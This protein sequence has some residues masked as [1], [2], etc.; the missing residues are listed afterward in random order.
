M[1]PDW[2]HETIV[3]A[4]SVGVTGSALRR[5]WTILP[6]TAMVYVLRTLEYGRKYD[7]P[8]GEPGYIKCPPEEHIKH[9]L[10]HAIASTNCDPKF[11]LEHLS[12]VVCRALFAITTIHNGT[13]NGNED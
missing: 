2:N 6:W 8:D 4:V 7:Q 10:E 13:E 11:R 12:S 5:D 9:M 1:N 3:P